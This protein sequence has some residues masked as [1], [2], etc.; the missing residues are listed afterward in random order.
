MRKNRTLD[1][2]RQGKTALGTWVQ[3]HSV[4][5]V[6]LLAA[7]GCMDWLLIDCEHAPMDMAAA[8][9]LFNTTTDASGGR[10]TPLARVASGTIDQ[11]KQVLDAGAQ[12]VL[13]PLVNTAEQA[14]QVVR[15]SRFPPDGERGSGSIFANMTYAATR[16]EYVANANHQVLVA[17]QIETKEAVENID[18]ILDV[19]GIDM[20]FVGPNDLTLSLGLPA[21]FWSD[22]PLFQQAVAKIIAA[23]QRRNIPLGTI[24][25]S[26]ADAKRREAE[27]FTFIGLGV[28]GIHMLA[29][30]GQQFADFTGQPEPPEGWTG[31][32]RMNG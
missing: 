23:C 12:G 18:A 24:Q 1:L 27:G 4:R 7:Q 5:A 19:P 30:V 21:S 16:P 22:E 32:T 13:V 10:V 28:D 9:L 31:L 3:L 6:R 20:V 26:A 14:A 8:M 29:S 11:I 15:F 25:M 17:I 2:L